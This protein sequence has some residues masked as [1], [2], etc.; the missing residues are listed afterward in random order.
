MVGAVVVCDGKIIG[1]GYHV[2]SGSPHAEV[3]AIRAVPDE[4]LLKRATLYVSLEPCSHFGKTPPCADLILEKKIPRIV[5]GCQD[6]FPEVAGRGVRKLLDAGC[7]V[8]TG[9]LERECRLLNK[10]F[11]T[12]HTRRRPYITLKWAESADGYLDTLRN[13]GT[14]VLLS[15]ELTQMQVHKQRAET[16]AIMV[17]TRTACLDNPSLSV[18]HWYG[19]NPVRIVLDRNLSLDASSLHLFDGSAHT[20]VFTSLSRPSSGEVEYITLNYEEDILPPIMDILYEKQVQSLLV[21]GGSRLLQS[22]LDAGLWDEAFVEKSSQWL[23]AGIKSPEVSSRDCRC[24]V[25]SRFNV[26]FWHYT[27]L[28]A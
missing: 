28:P 2:R 5:V 10:C 13:G 11:I 16:D 3:N 15:T 24:T 26:P 17:G 23:H 19:K 1:E 20:V 22:F 9:V 18:R 4:S 7:E 21:E 27:N 25:Q 6:P 12:Y 8:T 14:P